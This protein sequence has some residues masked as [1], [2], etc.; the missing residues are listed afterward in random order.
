MLSAKQGGNK[1]HFKVFGMTWQWYSPRAD[2]LPL[3]HWA[4]QVAWSDE[5]RL[6]SHHITGI[7]L[8]SWGYGVTMATSCCQKPLCDM[9]AVSHKQALLWEFAL[10]RA[11]RSTAP[12]NYRECVSS[13][14]FQRLFYTS[15]TS[16]SALQISTWWQSWIWICTK[17]NPFSVPTGSTTRLVLR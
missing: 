3:E 15:W 4:G 1:Y 17:S 7:W 6:L 16:E 2:T 13:T 14:A 12:N 11:A 10:C 8:C 9:F 5:S